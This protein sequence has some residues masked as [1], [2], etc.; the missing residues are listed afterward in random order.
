M[1][2]VVEESRKG[3]DRSCGREESERGMG[4][5]IRE[6]IRGEERS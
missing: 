5:G 4:A 2:M 3:D 1:Q 6:R